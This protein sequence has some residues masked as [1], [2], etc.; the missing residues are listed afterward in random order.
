MRL[1]RAPDFVIPVHWVAVDFL[2]GLLLGLEVVR[3]V[4]EA[5]LYVGGLQ[6]EHGV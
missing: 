1:Q 2:E 5:I 4:L 3:S 6:T